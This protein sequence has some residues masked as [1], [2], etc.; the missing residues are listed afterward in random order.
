MAA[1]LP[2]VRHAGSMR[3]KQ[4]ACDLLA[5]LTWCYYRSRSRRNTTWRVR[6]A[7]SA[8][9]DFSATPTSGSR[10]GSSSRRVSRPPP[11]GGASEGPWRGWRG[12]GPPPGWPPGAPRALGHS[13]PREAPA[14]LSHERA[15][16]ALPLPGRKEPRALSGAQATRKA[17]LVP[18]RPLLSRNNPTVNRGCI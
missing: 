1:N 5:K 17:L 11:E 7:R 10:R 2:S 9:G 12:A 13:L 4:D 15:L 6:S 16:C 3:R 14:G 18:S 8:S